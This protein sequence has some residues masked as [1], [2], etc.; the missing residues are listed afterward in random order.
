MS[1]CPSCGKPGAIP[2]GFC[3]YCGEEIAALESVSASDALGKVSGFWKRRS[4]L[5]KAGLIIGALIIVGVLTPKG[6]DKPA[7]ST[8][9][10]QVAAVATKAT[11]NATPTT[12]PVTTTTTE[13]EPAEVGFA[14]GMYKVGTDLPAGEYVLISGRG[15]CY[16][17]IT[18]D[19]SGTFES[20]V[21]NDNFMNRSIVTVADGQYIT[22]S[23]ARLVPAAQAT[24][25]APADGRLPE[26]MY[27]V[28]V[29]LPAGEYKVIPEGSGYYEVD[30]NSSHTFE[31]IVANDNFDTERYVTVSAGQY[32]KLSSA[33][34]VI[35]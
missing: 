20:I 33:S 11:P 34:I 8:T 5:G 9:T 21:A 16:F 31:A 14:A 30:R 25:A 28:G 15:S 35:K 3:Q 1:K 22:V 26:G 18:K 12:A 10:Q 32:L 17:Q 6:D 7:P 19:S 29:D 2:G 24:P 13:P 27:K 23:D 4:K